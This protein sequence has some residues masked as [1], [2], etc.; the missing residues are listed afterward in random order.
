MWRS[1]DYCYSNIWKSKNY[2]GTNEEAMNQCKKNNTKKE[3]KR[4]K[5]FT[6]AKFEEL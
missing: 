3:A 6:I 5:T 1:K 2:N 4:L